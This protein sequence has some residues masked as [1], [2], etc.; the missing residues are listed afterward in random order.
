M[1]RTAER[2][3]LSR[4]AKCC[5]LPR[6]VYRRY[7]AQ[8]RDPTLRPARARRDEEL[9]PQIERVW[10]ANIQVYGAD[11]VRSD[12]ML[13]TLLR[14][15][16]RHTKCM[17]CAQTGSKLLMQSATALDVKR[18]IDSFV[19]DSHGLVFGIVDLQSSTD[20]FGTPAGTQTPIRAA[21]LPSSFP[22]YV[23]SSNRPACWV[24]DCSR[25]STLHIIL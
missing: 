25:Q 8:R 6:R 17:A 12:E 7:A 24:G 23:R 2:A 1:T 16:S 14:P 19:R 10:R 3:G 5:G 21:A 15:G 22:R 9:V 4:S 11:K 20:L 18:L 13:S